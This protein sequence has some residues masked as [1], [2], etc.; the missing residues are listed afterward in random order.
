MSQL[1]SVVFS[2]MSPQVSV[3][4]AFYET[5]LHLQ[6][7]ETLAAFNSCQKVDFFKDGIRIKIL[8]YVAVHKIKIRSFLK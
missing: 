8:G 4:N 5:Y 6:F 3:C 7:I 1:C 2:E